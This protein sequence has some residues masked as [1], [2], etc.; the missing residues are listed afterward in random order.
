[1]IIE[2]LCLYGGQDMGSLLN[3]PK[4]MAITLNSALVKKQ[5]LKRKK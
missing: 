1:M 4:S 2:N 3:V 5:K